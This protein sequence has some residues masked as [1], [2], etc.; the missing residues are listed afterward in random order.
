MLYSHKAPDDSSGRPPR[1]I[2]RLRYLTSRACVCYCVTV[3][4]LICF[5]VTAED[6]VS[7]YGSDN[8]SSVSLRGI[9]MFNLL[10]LITHCNVNGNNR[11]EANAGG[12][13]QRSAAA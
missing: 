12:G 13:L 11:Q 6:N 1:E 8:Y 2:V 3:S 9:K 5:L 10:R 4:G 7:L